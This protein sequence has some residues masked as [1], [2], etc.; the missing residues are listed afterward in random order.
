MKYLMLLP[1]V[2]LTGCLTQPVN[3]TWPDVPKDLL[4]ACPAL[5][6]VD[7]KTDRL[8]DV[9][10][11]VADNYTHYHECQVKVDSWIEWYKN[12]KSINDSIK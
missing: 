10:R 9:V 1:L 12:Q 4:E 11:V 6:Q 7:P 5:Q 8:S 2:L 3:K